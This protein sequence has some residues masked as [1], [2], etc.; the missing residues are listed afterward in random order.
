MQEEQW[1][2]EVWMKLDSSQGEWDM[3]LPTILTTARCLL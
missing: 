1:E 2:G 3:I